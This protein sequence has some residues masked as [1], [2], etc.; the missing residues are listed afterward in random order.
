MQI[1]RP[2]FRRYTMVQKL[3]EEEIKI[4]EA[5]LWELVLGRDA[6]TVAADG[7]L[8]IYKT[9]KVNNLSDWSIMEEEVLLTLETLIKRLIETIVFLG[10]PENHKVVIIP[11]E[12]LHVHDDAIRKELSLYQKIIKLEFFKLSNKPDGYFVENIA[13]LLDHGVEV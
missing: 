4:L 8:R 9:L 7:V 10:V 12:V 11:F 6:A 13:M 3:T 2:L 1:L 5:K